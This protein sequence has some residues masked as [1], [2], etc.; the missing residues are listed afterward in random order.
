MKDFCEAIVAAAFKHLAQNP[1]GPLKCFHF[2]CDLNAVV[3][4]S[5]TELIEELGDLLLINLDVESYA[6]STP[7]YYCEKHQKLADLDVLRC[8]NLEK[9]YYFC[10]L[11]STLQT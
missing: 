11:V 10:G 3:V 2:G 6:A 8:L 9:S 5:E 7:R 4:R 1:R